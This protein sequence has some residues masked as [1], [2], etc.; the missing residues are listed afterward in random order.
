MAKETFYDLITLGTDFEKIEFNFD[1]DA[2]LLVLG[3]GITPVVGNVTFSWN[4]TTGS[5]DGTLVPLDNWIQFDDLNKSQMFLK[6]TNAGDKVRL[7]AW[8]RSKS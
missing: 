4:G 5:N 3:D 6:S 2:I 1:S 8:M 7:W